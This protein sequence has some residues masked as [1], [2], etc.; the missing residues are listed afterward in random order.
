[1]SEYEGE[2]YKYTRAEQ[3]Q[4]N[5]NKEARLAYRDG[6]KG[7]DKSRKK[8][9]KPFNMNKPDNGAGKGDDPRRRNISHDEYGLRYDLA[10]GKISMEEFE[11]G[12]KELRNEQN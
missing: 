1:M 7:A 8:G 4:L 3:R 2:E 9:W 12:M 5:K 10:T 6:D 11:E